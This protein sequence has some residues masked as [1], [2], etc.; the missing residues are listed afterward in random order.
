MLPPNAMYIAEFASRS[1]FCVSAKS[2]STTRTSAVKSS[3]SFFIAAIVARSASDSSGKSPRSFIRAQSL[4]SSAVRGS[5][6]VIGIR[7]SD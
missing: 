2:D 6:A 5:C 3:S 1:T 4:S 7:I